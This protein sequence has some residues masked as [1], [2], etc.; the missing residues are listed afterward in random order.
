MRPR[1]VSPSRSS[2][3]TASLESVAAPNRL[4][5]ANASDLPAA[6]PPVSPIV[7]GA[8]RP[9]RSVLVGLAAVAAGS[10]LV[11]AVRGIGTLGG[12]FALMGLAAVALLATLGAIVLR[13]R[14]GL[15]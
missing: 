6:M 10:G 3:T 7:S 4:K 13:T 1:S 2:W 14:L 11:G 15:V 12:G 5:A 8:T 9:R